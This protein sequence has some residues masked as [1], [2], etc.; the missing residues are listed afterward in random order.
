MQEISYLLKDLSNLGSIILSALL[1]ILIY[2]TGRIL[3][4]TVNKMKIFPPDAKNGVKLFITIFQLF[5][6]IIG[7]A[8]AFNTNPEFL[9]GS[10]TIIA[11]AI[12]F[13]STQ[14]AANLVGGLYIIITS[15]FGVGDFI[16]INGNSGLVMEIGLNYTKMLKLDKTVVTIPNSQLLSATLLNSNISL[17]HEQKVREQA[18][19]LQFN[20]VSLTLPDSF[21]DALDFKELIRYST[22]IQLKLN[23]LNPPLA[24]EKVKERMNKV[25]TDFADIFGFTPRYF[26][27]NHVFRQD[28]HIVITTD[29]ADKLI[30]NYPIFMEAIMVE[31][32]KEL[33]V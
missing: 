13:A 6:W 11:T 30:N 32:F 25:C 24:L 31:V 29:S 2:L 26:F 4:F 14:T 3:K 15:P 17:A 8:L 27:G 5:T 12:G 23:Q 33:Q 22:T 16:T 1:L 28:T 21:L 19:E 7:T 18:R 9:L 20:K 10:S